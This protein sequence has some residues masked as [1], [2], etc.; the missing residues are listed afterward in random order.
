L[1]LHISFSVNGAVIFLVSQ[2]RFPGVLDFFFSFFTFSFT[3][4]L[5]SFPSLLL[6]NTTNTSWVDHCRYYNTESDI[7]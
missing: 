1:L 3:S 5:P 7:G 6:D 4:D 2:T